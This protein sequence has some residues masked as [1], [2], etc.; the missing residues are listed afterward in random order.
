MDQRKDAKEQ[1]RNDPLTE[2]KLKG[3]TSELTRLKELWLTLEEPE[4]DYWRARLVSLK[5]QKEIRREILEKLKIDLPHDSCLTY[6][7]DWLNRQY[8]RLWQAERMQE[9]E[10]LLQKEHP[11]WT[12]DQLRE[13]VL[14]RAYHESLNFANF[15]LG[16]S[17]A[18]IDLADK[19]VQLQ[20]EKFQFD[21][22]K[23]CL[24]RLPEVQAIAAKDIP[25]EDKI[26][27]IRELLFLKEDNA[28]ETI[29]PETTAP[30][31][32]TVD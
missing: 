10:D 11:D 24:K 28:K 21:A 29:T 30:V 19:S 15:K 3:G 12:R 8:E 7:R 31:P 4:R 2:Q 17:T 14:K 23:A 26:Y 5:T 18:R 13:E 27:S 6:F 32:G 16:L 22:I 9:N 25:E 1:R 20:W